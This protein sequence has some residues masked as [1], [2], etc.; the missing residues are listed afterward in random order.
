M[1][2]PGLALV[3]VHALLH[4]GPLAVGGDEEAVEIEIEAVL[5]CGA[6]NLGDQSAGARQPCAVEADA[7]TELQ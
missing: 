3:A 1:I 2:T 4:D 6:I 5:N 7:V